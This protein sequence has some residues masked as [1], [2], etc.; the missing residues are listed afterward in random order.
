VLADRAGLADAYVHY[1][2]LSREAAHPSAQSLDRYFIRGREETPLQGM[3]WGAY[4]GDPDETGLTLNM[5]C[6]AMLEVCEGMCDMLANT[7]A[8]SEVKAHRS[9]HDKLNG[10]RL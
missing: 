9:V 6:L 10:G 7:G 3:R 8:L 2:V 1:A 4:A 5:A